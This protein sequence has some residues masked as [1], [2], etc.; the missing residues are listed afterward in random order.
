MTLSRSFFSTLF[1]LGLLFS[2][3]NVFAE[4]T[5]QRDLA[6][7][8]ANRQLVINFYNQF[9]NQHQVQQAAEVVA[10]NYIQH[11]PH[12]PDGKAPFVGYFEGYFKNNPQSKA[13]I[14]RS[15]ADNDLVYLHIHSTQNAEDSGQAVVDIFRVKNG[16]IVE[17]WDVIQDVPETSAN[18]NTMF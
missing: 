1:S 2:A 11:N 7:E 13:D 14:V 17:H 3:T 16:M 4:Q 6:K 18:A 5:V 12:V 15:T 8:E 9:F 10:D